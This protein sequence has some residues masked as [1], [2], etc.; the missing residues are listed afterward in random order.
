MKYINVVIENR[1][2]HTDNFFTYRT[3]DSKIKVG[4]KVLVP[5]GKGNKHKS[6]F[7]FECGNTP[8]CAP[9]IIKEIIQVD[10]D[11]SLTEEIISTASW[12]KQRYAVTYSDA[13]RCFTPN[14]KVSVKGKKKEPYKDIEGKYTHP[15]RLT[16]EQKN[17]ILEIN[18]A[19]SNRKQESFLI[20]GVTASGKTQVYMEAVE[21][22][23]SMGRKAIVLVPE[24][25]LTNQI[26]ENFAGRFGKDKIAVMHSKLTQ[27]ERYDEWQRISGSWRGPGPPHAC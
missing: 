4:D 24:I 25:S 1:S 3:D 6:G 22:C 9:E 12:M 8:S 17:A 13:L 10:E 5:F 23:I 18:K 15:S 21:K 16:E 11:E 7:V 26:I 27:R 20:H 19:I 2:R 14:V